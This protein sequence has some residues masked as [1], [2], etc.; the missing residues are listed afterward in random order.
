LNIKKVDD[1][2][3]VILTKE[4]PKVHVKGAPEAKIKGRNIL[5]MHRQGIK[6]H[7]AAALFHD[8]KVYRAV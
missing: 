1:K 4:K 7:C 6:G 5:T 8:G 3:M 2:P